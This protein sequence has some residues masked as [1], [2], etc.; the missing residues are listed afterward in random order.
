MNSNLTALTALTFRM[1][2]LVFSGLV[3]RY[4]ISV[5]GDW[6]QW[7][8]KELIKSHLTLLRSQQRLSNLVGWLNFW[9]RVW[10]PWKSVWKTRF[11]QKLRRVWN[12]ELTFIQFA[13]FSQFSSLK[14]RYLTNSERSNPK[15]L[16]S[17][18][19]DFE[20]LHHKTLSDRLRNIRSNSSKK[21]T[22]KWEIKIPI[23]LKI[24]PFNNRLPIS[25]YPSCF[26]KFSI[27]AQSIRISIFSGQFHLDFCS[28]VQPSRTIGH[29]L[30]CCSMNS[31]AW[32]KVSIK[33]ISARFD[34]WLKRKKSSHV[35]ANAKHLF[36]LTGWQD[37]E[38]FNVVTIEKPEFIFME[39]QNL[40]RTRWCHSAL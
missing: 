40:V 3:G 15:S 39:R 34:L 17:R 4:E 33:V 35:P 27:Q 6:E 31:T 1:W 8:V 14:V 11:Y 32:S 20:W 2:Q 26:W 30:D 19:P 22:L 23:K 38:H 18:N 16:K 37:L 29:W 24:I 13:S 21:W 5:R 10:N 36:Q 7:I 28:P 12:T 25:C 9:G